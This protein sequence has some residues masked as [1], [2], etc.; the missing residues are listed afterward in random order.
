MKE[1]V[2][3]DSRGCEK[4]SYWKNDGDEPLKFLKIFD[5]VKEATE[6]Y[7]DRD[8]I[9]TLEGSRLTYRE[10]FEKVCSYVRCTET[11]I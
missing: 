8:A 11:L 1:K 6:K 9:C 2:A 3:S 7:P 5:I 4:L 10:S